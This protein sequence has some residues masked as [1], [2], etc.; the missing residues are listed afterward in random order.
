MARF[1]K[2]LLMGKAGNKAMKVNKNHLKKAGPKKG[3]VLKRPFAKKGATALTRRNLNKLE[4][5]T[6]E[7][8]VKRAAEEEEK[9]EAAAESLKKNDVEAGTLKGMESTPNLL[10]KPIEA[11]AK[12]T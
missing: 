11:A 4:D 12:R 2:I 1:E 6:L 8:K 10:E 3:K 5:M 7:E 9:P